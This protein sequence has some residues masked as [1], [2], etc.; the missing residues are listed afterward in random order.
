MYGTWKGAA[1]RV[2]ELSSKVYAELGDMELDCDGESKYRVVVADLVHGDLSK[3]MSKY[4]FVT[5]A[6]ALAANLKEFG[7]AIPDGFTEDDVLVAYSERPTV[8][9]DA[10]VFMCKENSQEVHLTTNELGRMIAAA[11][12]LYGEAFTLS[13]WAQ[14]ALDK[15][16]TL[17]TL[18][19]MHPV[20]T[21][22]AWG[23]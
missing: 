22:G 2:Q 21:V 16:R 6:K 3:W 7:R 18:R 20:L 5:E 14:R 8:S 13:E 12:P 19:P 11:A 15:A 4:S 23:D 1:G 17:D 10:A 9:L